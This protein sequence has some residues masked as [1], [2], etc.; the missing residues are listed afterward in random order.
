MKFVLDTWGVKWRTGGSRG[1]I[2][3]CCLCQDR[4]NEGECANDLVADLLP[5]GAPAIEYHIDIGRNCVASLQR[6]EGQRVR[7]V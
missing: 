3:L 7:A 4:W 5:I 2:N 6:S 1:G